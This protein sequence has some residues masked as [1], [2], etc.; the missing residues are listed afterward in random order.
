MAKTTI[1][2]S[3]APDYI[4]V[5]ETLGFN[6]AT[7]GEITYMGMTP[8]DVVSINDAR[9]KITGIKPG[10]V[11]FTVKAQRLGYEETT[12]VISLRCIER[13]GKTTGFML[14]NRSTNRLTSVQTQDVKNPQDIIVKMP[15]L[16]ADST[17][18]TREALTSKIGL[19]VTPTIIDPSN[20]ETDVEGWITAS[21]YQTQVGFQGPHEASVWEYASDINFTNILD[22]IYVNRAADK[23]KGPVIHSLSTIYVRVKYVSD[24]VESY[25]SDPIMIT[26]KNVGR[27]SKDTL[28]KGDP[29]TGGY[30]GIVPHDECIGDRNYRGNYETLEK[31]NLK[32]F[33][34]GWQ[35]HKGNTLYYALRDITAAECKDPEISAPAG[36]GQWSY[37]NRELLPTPEWVNSVTGIGFGYTDNNGD[38]YSTGSKLV[39]AIQDHEL[40]WIKY[41]YKGKICYTP[42]KPICTTVCWNDIA[43][44]DIMYGERTFRGGATQMYRI[45][46]MAEDEYLTIIPG[47]MDGTLA[48][49]TQ[50]ELGLVD[51]KDETKARLTWI[52][53]TQEG[54]KRKVGDH[55]GTKIYETDPKSR[56]GTLGLVDG[57]SSWQMSYRPVI[58]LVTESGEPWRNWPQCVEADDEEFRYDKYTD[59]GYFGRVRADM[60]IR[61]DDLATN[62]GLT[63]GTSCFPDA[64]WFKFYWHGII[65][66]IRTLPMRYNVNSKVMRDAGLA[67]AFDTGNKLLKRMTFSEVELIM[68]IMTGSRYEPF[69]DTTKYKDDKFEC[70]ANG[71]IR[72]LMLRVN[73]ADNI[74][75]YNM[76]GNGN[77]FCGYQVG[78]NWDNFKVLTE[79]NNAN[80]DYI[81]NPTTGENSLMWVPNDNYFNYNSSVGSGISNTVILPIFKYPITS[82][83][84]LMKDLNQD[85]YYRSN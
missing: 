23:T 26:T 10:T 59:T 24:T 53:D 11:E 77:A 40:G 57:V 46:L 2:I 17:L 19:I 81:A 55:T 29:I 37:D 61:G 42:V 22:T 7:D 63:T 27:D 60:M 50:V 52:E 5:G 30:F 80:P 66:Y 35:V 47:L 4:Y 62:I 38:G 9:D 69:S 41:I 39:G 44:R 45:R 33:Y 18:V 43:K 68:G 14:H 65:I 12:L 13:Q 16:A 75:Y 32:K 28:L 76:I 51:D 82:H 20:G 3:N 34:K 21:D 74:D 48:N 64:G 49:F 6:L 15:K 67:F 31:Y 58:E 73:V 71:H 54:S 78:D 36:D 72:D 25:W 56:V 1:T 84:W 70:G 83:V 8:M 79:S 85:D